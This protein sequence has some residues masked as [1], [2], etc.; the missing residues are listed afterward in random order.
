MTV[1]YENLDSGRLTV[2]PDFVRRLR[3]EGLDTFESFYGDRTGTLLRDLGRRSNVRLALEKG[4][5]GIVCFL[6]RHERPGLAERLKAR[7]RLARPRSP[8]RTE[9][10]NIGRL[11]RLDIST[12]T[13]VALGEDP[14]TGRSFLVTAEIEGASP[15]D[16]FARDRLTQAGA[17]APRR[18]LVRRLGELVGK[19]HRAGLTHRD[20]YLCH[21]FVRQE[22]GD[23][24]LHLIDL[25]R[26]GRRI[27]GRR[28]HVKDVAQLEYSRPAG[29]FSRTDGVRFLHAYFLTGRLSPR[30]KRFARSVLSKAKRMRRRTREPRP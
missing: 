27:L 26:A 7:L 1:H 20:L 24:R 19:L 11:G 17:A 12:M 18:K 21:V 4:G 14:H 5:E 29:T 9:W 22:R 6:K 28:W 30:Q 13:P 25:Q 10:D 23:F 3:R 8:A 15:A 2:H 16:D